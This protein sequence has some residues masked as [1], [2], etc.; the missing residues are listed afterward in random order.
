MFDE[1][2]G[3]DNKFWRAVCIGPAHEARDAFLLRALIEMVR[4]RDP[5]LVGNGELF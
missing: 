2:H 5:L 4:H 1:R 3:I